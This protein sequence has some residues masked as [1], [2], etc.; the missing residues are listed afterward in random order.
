MPTAN[1]RNV[2]LILLAV[3]EADAAEYKS[4]YPKNLELAEARVYYLDPPRMEGLRLA[5]AY[6]TN[7]ARQHPGYHRAKHHLRNSMSLLGIPRRAL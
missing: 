5:G 3:D 7:A 1:S 6:A 2:G 4:W